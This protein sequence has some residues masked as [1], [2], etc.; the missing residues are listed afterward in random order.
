MDNPRRVYFDIDNAMI[1]FP[2]QNWSF[3]TGK[4]KQ[5]RISQNSINPCVVRVV[6]NVDDDFNLNNIK[7]LS[8]KN[9]ILIKL[10]DLDPAS[11]YL[12][13]NYRDERTSI[14]DFYEPTKVSVN[15]APRDL[16]LKSG[17]YLTGVSARRDAV[18]VNGFG[19]LTIEKPLV[20]TDPARVV[21][22]LPNTV[23]N[24]EI[25]N[26][27]YNL[28]DKETVKVGQFTQ[29]KARVV[30]QTPN[31]NDFIPIFM[32]DNQSL[33]IANSK[34]ITASGLPGAVGKI[35]SYDKTKKDTTSRLDLTF[36][37]PLIHGIERTK[38]NI[39]LYLYNS[40]GV[41]QSA[42]SA[43][44]TD[45]IFTKSTL[46]TSGNSTKITIPLESNM[47]VNTYIGADNKTLS[48]K[49]TEQKLAP[50]PAEQ[51]K[52]VEP[53]KPVPAKAPVKSNGKI[54][55][56]DPGHG[57]ADCGALKEDMIEKDVNLIIAK[58]VRD[59]L[60]KQG[61]IVHMTRDDDSY[62]SLED[63][64]SFAENLCPEIFISMHV[65][66]SVRPEINGI[67]THYWR[68]ESLDLAKVIHEKMISEVK[69]N[70]RGT[71][72]SKFYVIN[73]TT[74]PAIL[75]EIGFLSN[76]IERAQM[77]ADKRKDATAKAVADGVHHYLKG[78]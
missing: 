25:R 61:Y 52:S 35:Q 23:V 27:E 37:T 77:Q 17:Y 3:E 60:V 67:E 66:S 32:A 64:V 42:F 24:P 15:E 12:H 1:T 30:I 5:V 58:K 19:A 36:S 18:L 57:G 62:V 56:L 11:D 76:D 34:K 78:K 22:D 63:R 7:L 68:E 9:T 55:V 65:N 4:I 45:S 69:A 72:K 54:I 73:H 49:I 75:V 10:K 40:S 33:F 6:M 50:K 38:D 39:S 74:M 28:N 47:I 2:K 14:L 16:K 8:I 46:T 20:L 29:N 48:I 59:L 26:V 70:N 21:F 43:A 44:L 51:P 13:N 41:T 53:E 71:F 31:V